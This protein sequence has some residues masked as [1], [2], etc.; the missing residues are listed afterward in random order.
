[1]F[2]QFSRTVMTFLMWHIAFT[3]SEVTIFTCKKE[4]TKK[5][6]ICSR[7]VAW[8]AWNLLF[9]GGNFREEVELRS[10]IRLITSNSERFNI[11]TLSNVDSFTY[12]WCTYLSLSVWVLASLLAHLHVW[13]ESCRHA[14]SSFIQ[15][16]VR[17]ASEVIFASCKSYSSHWE[18][19]PSFCCLA[20]KKLENSRNSYVFFWFQIFI[21]RGH[22]AL[23][24]LP[25]SPIV[26]SPHSWRL[27]KGWVQV[28]FLVADY[29]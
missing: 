12:P 20:T 18:M 17:T 5:P 3:F 1:M 21:S 6:P 29:L 26:R 27:H 25:P 22:A 23:K 15:L 9:N 8:I 19:F 28:Y 4:S 24:D 7:W 2:F 10:L 11:P 16:T 13:L 14:L